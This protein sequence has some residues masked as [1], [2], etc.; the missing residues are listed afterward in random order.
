MLIFNYFAL[1]ITFTYIRY[2]EICCIKITSQC[3]IL[4]VPEEGWFGQPKY[5]THS[6]IIRTTFSPVPELS[7]LPTPY[8]AEPGR[9][10]TESRITCMRILRTNQSK[11]TR[12]HTTLLV[13]I[14]RAMPFSARAL[15]KKTHFL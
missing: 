12:V 5:S 10:K 8:R 15:K 4:I 7:F 2:Y 11:I 13:L 1:S 3:K 6:K 14:C 9:A